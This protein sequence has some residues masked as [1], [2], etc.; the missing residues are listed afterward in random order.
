MKQL[1][2]TLDDETFESAERHARKTGKPLTSIVLDWL[3][4]LSVSSESEFQQMLRE[5]ETLRDQF[6]KSGR[7]FSADERLTR[8][9]L[10]ERHALR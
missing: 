8:D 4:H 6:K 10:H 9:Q 2:L 5:E 3:K 1:T 7:E